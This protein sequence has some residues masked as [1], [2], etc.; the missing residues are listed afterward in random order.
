VVSRTLNTVDGLAQ[1]SFL[2]YGLLDRRADEYGLSMVQ[3]RLLGVLRDRRPTMNELGEL[4][5]LDKSSVSGLVDRAERR[6]LVMRVPSETD[7]RAVRVVLADEGRRI[8]A[9]AAADFAADLKTVLSSL[10]APERSTLTALISRILLDHAD[11]R[12]IDLFAG[13]ADP[14]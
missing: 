12:G 9:A 7:R 4:L 3:T 1:L 2:V 10:S 11:Q 8:V 13:V 5:G 6:R 14:A